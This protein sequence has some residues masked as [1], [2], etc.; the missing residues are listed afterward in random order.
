MF[1][2]QK[3]L[4]ALLVFGAAGSGKSAIANAILAVWPDQFTYISTGDLCR[5]EVA[6]ED[7]TGEKETRRLKIDTQMKKPGGLVDTE[8]VNELFIEKI[9]TAVKLGK[10]I[11]IDG[12]GRT[13]GQ[14]AKLDSL[15]YENDVEFVGLLY[16]HTPAET[17]VQRMTINRAQDHSE[18]GMLVRDEDK[19]ETT[20]RAKVMKFFTEIINVLPF[21][22]GKGKVY[23]IDGTKKLNEVQLSVVGIVKDILKTNEE[24]FNNILEDVR[25]MDSLLPIERW[26]KQTLIKYL[27]SLT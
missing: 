23:E 19:D 17:C 25:K 6:R 10:H 3:K 26:D 9:K 1:L 15:L 4:F 18:K 27:R 20:A 16:A 21:Y 11:L 2:N 12:Y 22:Q 24:R 8:I 14:A 5:E 13:L 7:L